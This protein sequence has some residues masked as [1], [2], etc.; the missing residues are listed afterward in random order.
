MSGA[1]KVKLWLASVF[2]MLFG[3]VLSAVSLFAMLE[4]IYEVPWFDYKIA[5]RE[6]CR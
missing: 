4:G 6:R 3:L 5:A 1:A 2:L